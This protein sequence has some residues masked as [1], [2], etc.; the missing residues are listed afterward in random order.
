MLVI[1]GASGM[2]G[3]PAIR[4]LVSRGETI[5]AFTSSESSA[6]RLKELGV[7]ETVI[8]DFRHDQEI[9]RAMQGADSVV[10][11]PPSV[12]EDEHLIGFQTLEASKAAGVKHFVFVSCFHSQISDLRH[13]RNKLLVEE[14]VIKSGL[15]YTILQP[16][17]FMQNI[18]FIWANIEQGRFEWPWNPQKRYAMLDTEDLGEA[19]ATVVCEPRFRG[20]TYELCSPDTISVAE[21]AEQLSQAWGKPLRAGWQRAE[22][23]ASGMKAAGAPAWSIETVLGMCRFHDRH[24]Y[25]GG[26]AVVLEALIGHK[27]STYRD[28]A[29]R[30]VKEKALRQ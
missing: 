25:D 28:F 3:A 22:E 27:A 24:G 6:R 8:G 30:L 19:I 13:H 29:S 5:R 1:T 15:G 7:S 2:V 18:G 10:H 14:A 23:W 21:M 16:A 9:R 11:I 17:M 26:N 4:Q 12:V 20:G